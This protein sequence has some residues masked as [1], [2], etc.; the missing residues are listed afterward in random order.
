MALSIKPRRDAVGL[1]DGQ[2]LVDGAWRPAQAEQTWRHTH[3]ATGEDVGAFAVAEA[4]DV[5]AAVRAARR[6]FDEGPWP[7]SRAKERIRVLRR[8]AELV[9]EHAT[10]LLTLQALDNSVPLTFGDTYA[11]SVECVAD[12][13]DHHAGWVDKLA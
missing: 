2:L 5:D 9:R 10:E 7:R 1:T 3:P 6:A 13:F 12:I 11:M 4:D 8:T